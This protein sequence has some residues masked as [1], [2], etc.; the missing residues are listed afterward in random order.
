MKIDFFTVAEREL[1]DAI[2]YYNDEQQGLGDEFA[3]EASR[4]LQRIQEF[5]LAWAP[6]SKKSRRCLMH[7]FPYGII[8]QKRKNAIM[9][10]SVMNLHR[11]PKNW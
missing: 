3:L 2:D 9:I 6:L 5:P 10:V 11:K 1:L 8:Y 7:R 4:A